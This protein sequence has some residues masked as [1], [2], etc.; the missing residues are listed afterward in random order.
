MVNSEEAAFRISKRS[1]PN[2]NASFKETEEVSIKY[3]QNA[4]FRVI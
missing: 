4:R 2:N 3:A 1:S